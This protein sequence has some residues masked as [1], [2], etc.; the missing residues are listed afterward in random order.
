LFDILASEHRELDR[1]RWHRTEGSSLK[2]VYEE[3]RVQPG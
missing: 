1:E 3:R 2:A